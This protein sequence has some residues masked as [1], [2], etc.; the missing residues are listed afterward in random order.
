[1][2]S[3]KQQR[4]PAS[5]K[6]QDTDQ[7]SPLLSSPWT[8]CGMRVHFIKTLVSLCMPNVDVT[9]EKEKSTLDLTHSCSWGV[10]VWAPGTESPCDTGATNHRYSH[11][12]PTAK[13]QPD[14]AWEGVPPGGTLQYC[15]KHWLLQAPGTVLGHFHHQRT[16]YK[17]RLKSLKC[18]INIELTFPTHLNNSVGL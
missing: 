2:Y 4:D 16:K 18:L 8:L 13:Q 14:W 15:P 3:S 10:R 17:V 9:P 7:Y 12:A 11:L 5:N 6:V 1:M